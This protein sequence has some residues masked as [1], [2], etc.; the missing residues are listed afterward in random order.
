[1]SSFNVTFEE[2]GGSLFASVLRNVITAYFAEHPSDRISAEELAAAVNGYLAEHPIEG[3]TAENVNS[4]I[5]EYMSAHPVSGGVDTEEVNT[6]I[7]DYLANHPVSGVKGDT[8]AQGIQGEKG[9]DGKSAYQIALDNGFVGSESEWL[10]S[11]KGAKG[12]AVSVESGEILSLSE[13]VKTA[14][15][16]CFTH[17][18]WT[19]AN[20]Q[21]H[22]NSLIAAFGGEPSQNEPTLDLVKT[23]GMSF[24]GN[25]TDPVNNTSHDNRGAISNRMPTEVYA[26]VDSNTYYG[27]PIDNNISTIHIE[28]PLIGGLMVYSPKWQI[29]YDSGWKYPTDN[30]IEFNVTDYRGKYFVLNFKRVDNSVVTQNDI[31][32][33]SV[34]LIKG[35]N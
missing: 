18:A 11:L 21:T 6:I 23:A 27:I 9:A 16:D 13:N 10:A 22:I 7:A 24:N 8:G 15:I 25:S 34:T 1:M 5:S 29:D 32:A 26:T 14:L 30:Q 17:V 31:D 4:L 3:L 35:D 20:G 28:S 19:D 2:N 33:I 12:D